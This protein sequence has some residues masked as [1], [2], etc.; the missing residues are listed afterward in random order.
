MD[1][2]QWTAHALEIILFLPIDMSFYT[3]GIVV[4]HVLF[5]N[6]YNQ[7]SCLKR[8]YLHWL[9]VF[10]FSCFF[11]PHFNLMCRRVACHVLELFIFIKLLPLQIEPRLS[12]SRVRSE[13]LSILSLVLASLMPSTIL[14]LIRE[15]FKVLNS[16]VSLKTVTYR[17]MVSPLSCA[18][19][20]NLNA[21]LF[22][23]K[24]FPWFTVFLKF[25]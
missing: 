1:L 21:S 13:I 8:V 22:E 16:H 3:P 23:T 19:E 20:K 25:L 15:F 10:F 24:L 9:R 14:S 12:F 7:I 18:L 11:I 5:H 4:H 2:F 6:F 17:S